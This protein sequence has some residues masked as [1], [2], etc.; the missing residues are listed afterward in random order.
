MTCTHS[1]VGGPGGRG[2]ESS[3]SPSSKSLQTQGL[4]F[5]ADRSVLRDGD[6]LG[7]VSQEATAGTTADPGSDEPPIRFLGDEPELYLAYNTKLVKTLGANVRG[8]TEDM[9][10]ACA[11]AWIQFF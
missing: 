4:R 2:F 6:R 3:R 9:E 11:F 8:A 10:D 5:A 1:R 7:T